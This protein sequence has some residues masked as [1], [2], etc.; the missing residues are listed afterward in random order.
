MSLL[1]E[2]KETSQQ[3]LP[4]NILLKLLRSQEEYDYYYYEDEEDIY[5][6]SDDNHILEAEELPRAEALLGKVPEEKQERLFG[7]N[8]KLGSISTLLAICAVLA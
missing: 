5:H 2:V 3:A 4:A 6:D 7:S 1:H 8:F